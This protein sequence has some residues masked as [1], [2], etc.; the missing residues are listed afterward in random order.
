[1]FAIKDA[2]ERNQNFQKWGTSYFNKKQNTLLR[3]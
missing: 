3:R 2:Q 1:M